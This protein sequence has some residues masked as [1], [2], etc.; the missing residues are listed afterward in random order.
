V[1]DGFGVRAAL[2]DRAIRLQAL[3][4]LDGVH[5]IAVVADGH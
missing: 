5:Q 1:N 3:A 2:E 4:Q